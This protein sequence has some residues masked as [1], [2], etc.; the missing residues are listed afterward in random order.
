MYLHSCTIATPLGDMLAVASVRGL[1]LLA[2]SDQKSLAREL[3]QVQAVYP[4]ALVSNP[5][6]NNAI[7]NS[8]LTQTH[9][10]LEQY[11]ARQRQHFDIALDLIGT[12]FQHAAWQALVQIPYGQTR[13]YA[14]QACAI[15]KPTAVRAV[16][17]ANAANKVSIIVPCHRVIGSDGRLTGFGGGLHRKRAL[18]DLELGQDCQSRTG[19]AADT[20]R[21]L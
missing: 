1:C 8:I 10:Q 20:K 19:L 14:E 12:V 2:F 18:L 6:N 17:A 3:A 9:I 5:S 13:S 11:F 21:G 15:A 7:L 4:T 16:A